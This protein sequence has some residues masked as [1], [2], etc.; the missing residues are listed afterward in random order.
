MVNNKR[1]PESKS[2]FQGISLTG[3]PIELRNFTHNNMQPFFG[4]TITKILDEFST[5]GIMENGLVL[6]IIIKKNKN[7]NH[8][9]NLKKYGKCLWISKFRWLYVR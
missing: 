7:K 8:F 6:M 1:E 5:R 9:F 3:N 4:S 2:G